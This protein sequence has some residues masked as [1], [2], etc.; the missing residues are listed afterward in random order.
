M[1]KYFTKLKKKREYSWFGRAASMD[2]KLQS[3]AYGVIHIKSEGNLTGTSIN[4]GEFV[5]IVSDDDDR[6]FVG[7]LLKLYDDG[8]Q[9]SFSKHAVVQW[10]IRF[11][12]VPHSKQGLLGREAHPQ[13]I[14]LHEVSGCDNDI[15]AETVI[16]TVKVVWLALDEAFPVKSRE[17]ALF[18]KLSWNGKAFKPVPANMFCNVNENARKDS[19]RKKSDR[20]ASSWKPM[21]YTAEVG[22]LEMD[23]ICS[24]E[25]SARSVSKRKDG[26]T[27]LRCSASKSSPSKDQKL[28]NWGVTPKARK[29]LQLTGPSKSPGKK[30]NQ[31]DVFA[32]LFDDSS[33]SEP[34]ETK[35]MKR[36]VA[37]NML[38]DSPRKKSRSDFNRVFLTKL[39]P[40]KEP[41]KQQPSEGHIVLSPVSTS[42]HCRTESLATKNNLL[43]DISRVGEEE[44]E[45][46]TTV[47]TTRSRKQAAT[48]ES[49]AKN[50]SRVEENGL[51]TNGGTDTPRSRRKSAQ[52]SSTRFKQQIKSLLNSDSDPDESINDFVPQEEESDQASSSGDEEESE[53]V[54]SRSLAPRTPRSAQKSSTRTPAKTPTKTSG[55]RTPRTPQQP[56]PRIPNRIH[57]AKK[58]G[59][60]LEEARARLHVSAVPES[61]PCREQEFQDVYSFVESKLIDGTGGCMYISGVPGTGKTAT[62]HEVIRCLQYAVE[63][64][65]LPSF[66]FIEINGM[67]LT[68]PHQAYVHILKFLTGQKATTNHAAELLEKRFSIPAPKRE[69]TVLLVDELDLLWTRKQNVMYN[70]FDWPT[71]KQAKLVV[72]AIA[73][74]MDLPERILMNRVAS[75]LGLTRMSFQPY[76]FKQLQQIITSRLNRIKAFEDDAIQLVARKVAALSGD[77]RRC[78]DICRRATEICEI[79]NPKN[80]L[81]GMAHVMEALDEMFSSPYISAIRSASVQEQVFLRAVIAE[82]RRLGLEEATFQQ[83]YQQHIGLSR[84]EGLQPLS[85]SETMAVCVRLGA[86]RLLLVESCKND[87]HLRVRLNVSQDDILYALKEEE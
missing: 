87:L 12:E 57:P 16:G 54:L 25:D 19:S 46:E 26:E 10:F 66:Q 62:V 30:L 83:V 67:K 44:E 28:D 40:L 63:Q 37:F 65:E 69:S 64:D 68:D 72:L 34:L 33:A 74:T 41:R 8:L 22:D 2:R 9:N 49:R 6:P 31:E 70:I 53:R 38:P 86:C 80:R 24:L 17:D 51:K 4:L 21:S 75:R 61:L 47:R 81:V 76:T 39:S 58:P 3:S 48:P 45:S 5:L 82:F 23:I 43:D 29:K 7:K 79:A 36:Q 85:M 18:V 50:E 15:D 32:E 27:E 73:N 78:L 14:F 11:E 52:V 42:K 55:A 60:V 56:T 59:N 84:I 77:A 1:S 35:A 20:A 71:R 13:E